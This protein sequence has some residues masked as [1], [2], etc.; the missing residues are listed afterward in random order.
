MGSQPVEGSLVGG[1]AATILPA[2]DGVRGW[3]GRDQL[4]VYNTG[5]VN[6]MNIAFGQTATS[7]DILIQPMDCFVLKAEGIGGGGGSGLVPADFVS[8]I[9]AG[10]TTYVVWSG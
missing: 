3:L 9:S 8:A 5:A 4:H 10:G 7:A 6:P 1:V 2:N